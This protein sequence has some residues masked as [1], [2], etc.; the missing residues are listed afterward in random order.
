MILQDICELIVDCPHTTAKD[1][2][3]GFPLI[4]TPNIGKGRLLLDGVHRVSKDVYEKRNLRATPRTDDIIFAR[5]APPGNA[6]LVTEGQMICLGQRTV[7]IRP[8]PELVYPKFLVYYLL[9][10]EQQYKLLGSANGATV[11]HVNLPI[12]RKMPVE[13]PDMEIQIKIADTI[14]AYDDFIE[15]NQKQIKLLEEATHRLYKEWFVDL[16]FPGYEN[17]KVVSGLPVG[18]GEGTLGDIATFKRGKTIT[19]AQVHDGNVPVVAGGLEPAY[20]HNKSNTVAP[21]ITVSGSGANAG[22]A[23]LYNVDVFASDCSFADSETTPFLFFAYCFIKANKPS[24]DA[25]QKGAAQP[26][27]Y[28]KDINALKLS[29][30]MEELLAIFCNKVAPYFEKIKTLQKQI[31]LLSQARDRLLPKLMSGEIEV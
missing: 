11:V 6:A 12:I 19:K 10:P 25:L 1:E 4:R 8:N 20:Y 7:L 27:V 22:F 2:G 30:P 16:H 9:A 3:D 29:I 26:H 28:A 21:V 13:L 17:V 14:T 31:E 23:R 24:L 15:N 18:W 5:E